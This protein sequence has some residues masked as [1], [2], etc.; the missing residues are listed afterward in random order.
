M[1]ISIPIFF[2]FILIKDIYNEPNF[3]ECGKVGFLAKNF[4]SC[5]DKKPFD[6]TKYCCFLK[7]GKDQECV[8][9]LKK[10]IDNDAVTMTIEELEKG[11]YEDW[12]DNNGYNLNRYYDIINSLECDKDIFIEYKFFSFLFFIILVL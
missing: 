10:D 5:K 12:E 11:I 1:L 3:G 6:D 2:F 4:D 9:I 8:E 7:A